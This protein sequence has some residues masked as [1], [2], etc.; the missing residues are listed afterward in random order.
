M[1]NLWLTMSG[2]VGSTSLE[3]G[4][5]LC[6]KEEMRKNEIRVCAITLPG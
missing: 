4:V 6:S 3:H 2:S 5:L 1:S